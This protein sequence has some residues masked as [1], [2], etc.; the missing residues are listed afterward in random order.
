M[1]RRLV[2]I[3]L[4]VFIFTAQ[5]IKVP[6]I[7]ITNDDDTLYVKLK[8]PVHANGDIYFLGLQYG[9]S[10]ID[11]KGEKQVFFS[12]YA[13]EFQFLWEGDL[14]RMISFK[15]TKEIGEVDAGYDKVFLHL[16]SNVRISHFYYYKSVMGQNPIRRKQNGQYFVDVFKRKDEPLFVLNRFEFKNKA[17][18]Y[19]SDCPS[20]VER[21]R[22]KTYRINDMTGLIWFYNY[23]C[24]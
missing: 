5:A 3:V 16:K 4:L 6:G 9:T 24:K 19:F 7:I 2:V 21:I 8:I 10:Y 17:M 22:N 11:S 20:L 18:A 23:R 12:T 1:R 15:S 14:I 13:K